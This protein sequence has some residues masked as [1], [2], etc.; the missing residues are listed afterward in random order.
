M[1]QELH[2]NALKASA[3]PAH[4]V[5]LLQ[6]QL[7]EADREAR[8][9]AVQQQ[10]LTEALQERQHRIADLQVQLSQAEAAR[11]Q[12]VGDMVRELELQHSRYSGLKSERDRLQRTVEEL[13]AQL[14]DVAARH[15]AAEER[16]EL[17]ERQLAALDGASTQADVD[18]PSSGIQVM[19]RQDPAKARVLVVDS[20]RPNLLAFEAI[21]APL[22]QDLV[23][24]N[25]GTEAIELS[26]SVSD[27]CLIIV[28]METQDMDAFEVLAHIKRRIKT[29]DIPVIL[30]S[31]SGSNPHQTFRAYAAGA[32][33]FLHKPI[34]PWVLR[35]KVA[36]FVELF[37]A[38]KNLL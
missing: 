5:Q 36:V 1:M 18:A 25:S 38:R 11:G 10:A 9:I 12:Q 20:S 23:L 34:D 33:D 3:S 21:L 35:A 26:R 8:A 13:Q 27:V 19:P 6:G 31:S 16:C 37:L 32:V 14:N 4:A 22:N 15:L 7:A 30:V 2:R 28:A 17:L 29:R 24:A